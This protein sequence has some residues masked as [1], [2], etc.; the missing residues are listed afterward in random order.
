MT[1][2]GETHE[3]MVPYAELPASKQ[4]QDQPYVE[5]SGPWHRAT[6]H[7]RDAWEM[8]SS[9]WAQEAFVSPD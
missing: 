2:R 9:R 7:P 6:N 8:V 5:A 4:N 3:A 1:A